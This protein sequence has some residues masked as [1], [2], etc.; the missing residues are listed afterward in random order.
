MA[1]Y[2][3]KTR[4]RADYVRTEKEVVRKL[5]GVVVQIANGRIDPDNPKSDHV[6]V[7]T[8]AFKARTTQKQALLSLKEAGKATEEETEAGKHRYICGV[9]LKPKFKPNTKEVI[10]VDDSK[11]GGFYCFTPANDAQALSLAAYSQVMHKVEPGGHN[12]TF[13]NRMQAISFARI[14]VRQ[15]VEG[16]TSL[17][18]AIEMMNFVYLADREGWKQSKVNEEIDDLGM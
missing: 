11:V 3:R 12:M 13:A 18:D 9:Y 2:Q 16:M 5:S 17:S 15:E 14:G 7:E 6:V 4:S 8:L 1:N 10:N